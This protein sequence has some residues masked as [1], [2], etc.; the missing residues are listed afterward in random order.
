MEILSVSRHLFI[1]V[2]NFVILSNKF[3]CFEL[4]LCSFVLKFRASPSSSIHNAVWG[5]VI[6]L[7]LKKLDPNRIAQWT[8]QSRAGL[9]N[10]SWMC[11]N[12]EFGGSE[13]KIIITEEELDNE[14]NYPI[15]QF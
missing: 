1:N 9:K 7:K 3:H 6:I 10:G 8:K 2:H 15:N 5:F 4:L 11:R 14:K 12:L 13:L